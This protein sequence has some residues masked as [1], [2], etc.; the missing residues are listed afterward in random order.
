MA[1]E[2]RAFGDVG[3]PAA[4]KRL[5]EIDHAR[6]FDRKSRLRIDESENLRAHVSHGDDRLVRCRC[7]NRF[8]CCMPYS[9]ELW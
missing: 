3:N 8:A 9:L 1:D 5:A 6:L 2:G 4:R 7:V